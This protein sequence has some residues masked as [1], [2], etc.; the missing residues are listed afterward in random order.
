MKILATIFLIITTSVCYCYDQFENIQ[1]PDPKIN[2][3]EILGSYY[4]QDN[5]VSTSEISNIENQ[6]KDTLFHIVMKDNT[7]YYGTIVSQTD[8]ELVFLTQT[9]GEITLKK[10]FIKIMEKVEQANIKD[11]IYW[12][13]NPSS[14]R[15]LLSPSGYG[16]KKGEGYYQNIYVFFNSVFYGFTDFFSVGLGTELLT[17]FLGHP[18]YFIT[19]KFSF[20]LAK[21]L[22]LGIGAMF[23]GII[24]SSSNASLTVGFGMLTYGNTDNNFSVGGGL[25][26]GD[27]VSEGALTISGMVRAG[28]RISFVSENWFSLGAKNIFDNSAIFSYAIRLMG[29]EYSFDLGFINT[30]EIFGHFALG[31]PYIDFIMKF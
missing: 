18:T 22:N 14:T 4:A 29:S 17:T 10:S 31:I 6:K 5:P 12:F 11:G 7:G 3:S 20:E 24:S 2:K 9:I 21:N 28:K 15:Y 23:F 30:P 26:S 25:V 13:P 27:G 1:L 16:L 8:E 19:P